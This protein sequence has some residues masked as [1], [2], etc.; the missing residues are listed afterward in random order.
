[1]ALE[2]LRES[3]ETQTEEV[4]DA[5]IA[6]EL[7]Y[8]P[9]ANDDD[10]GMF[11]SPT[12]DKDLKELYPGGSSG[13]IFK[14]K[15]AGGGL[16]RRSGGPAMGAIGLKEA[17]TE[18]PT[19]KIRRKSSAA[20]GVDGM[21]R[22]KSSVKQAGSGSGVNTSDSSIKEGTELGESRQ[23]HENSRDLMQENRKSKGGDGEEMT[24]GPSNS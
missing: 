6:E 20:P 8:D 12:S 3:D 24:D 21:E 19:D 17:P 16:Q 5:Q 11:L 15:G 10:L 7:F 9:D 22:R 13:Q 18:K 23:S 1:M 2:V 14:G 4:S